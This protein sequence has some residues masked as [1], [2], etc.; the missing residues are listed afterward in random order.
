MFANA[1][2]LPVTLV[3]SQCGRPNRVPADRLGD[4]PKCGQC[5]QAL[6]PGRAIELSS[7]IFSKFLK[8]N[9]LPVVVDFW[10]P[11]CGPCRMMAPEY[12][13][14]AQ[15]LQSRVLLAKLNTEAHSQVAAPF[16]I[17]G[18]PTLVAFRSGQEVARQSGAMNSAQIVAWVQQVLA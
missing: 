9:D 11:W 2:S 17:T 7:E 12:S 18:I 14:A 13:A 1:D 16:Q 8:R 4:G 6:L 5:H 10:A 3:C 15:R